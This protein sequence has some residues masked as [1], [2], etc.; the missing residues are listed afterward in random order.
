MR[1]QTARA[2]DGLVDV[3]RT[4]GR[5]DDDHA[6]ALHRPVEQLKALVDDG[7]PIVRIFPLGGLALADPVDLVDE[8]NAGRDRPGF[9]ESLDHLVDHVVQVS[10]LQEVETEVTT[11]GICKLLQSALAKVVLPVPGGPNSSSFVLMSDQPRI[12]AL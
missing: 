11:S 6:L 12:P 9:R 2:F 10:A 8:Q 5:A 4:I 3:V 7:V 1:L